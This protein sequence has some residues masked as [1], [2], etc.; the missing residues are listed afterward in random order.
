MK[1]KKD[2]AANGFLFATSHDEIVEKSKTEGK[3]RA[4]VSLESKAVLAKAFK[5]RYPFLDIHVEEISGTEAGERFLLELKAG[6]TQWDVSRLSTETFTDYL[7]HGKKVDILGMAEHGVLSIPT[8]T[9]DPKSRKAFAVSSDESSPQR[10]SL[11][12]R[13]TR[14]T[15]HPHRVPNTVPAPTYTFAMLCLYSVHARK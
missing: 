12:S 15:D 4:I 14:P 13:N 1:A 11:C 3:F 6:R 2:A 8:K 5:E 7:Q 9:I 10:S